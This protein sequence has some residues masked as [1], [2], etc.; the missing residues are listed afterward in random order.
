MWFRN[1]NKKPISELSILTK[2]IDENVVKEDK[3][4]TKAI[5]LDSR[6]ILYELVGSM[7]WSRG[8]GKK[9]KDKMIGG[10]KYSFQ[11]YWYVGGYNIP[12]YIWKDAGLYIKLT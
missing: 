10:K 7:R 12:I 8:T 3:P 9:P 6:D 2:K 4:V 5:I 1:K 11:G